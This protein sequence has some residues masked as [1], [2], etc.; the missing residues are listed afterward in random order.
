M[1]KP[2][3][4]RE[5][6]LHAIAT[7]CECPIEPVT[8][9]EMLMAEHAKREAQGGGSGGVSSWNDLTDNPFM[10]VSTLSMNE[11]ETFTV[12]KNYAEVNDALLGGKIVLMSLMGMPFIA[13]GITIE[14][15]ITDGL[16]N[17]RCLPT[18]T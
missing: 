11:D 5:M 6:F 7:G 3:N 12:N 16:P 13:T 8:R 17:L 10:V 18:P 4:R 1:N 9:E 14:K 15:M 2:T